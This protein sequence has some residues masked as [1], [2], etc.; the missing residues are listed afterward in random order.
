[1]ATLPVGRGG[2]AALPQPC[3][4]ALLVWDH[5]PLPEQSHGRGLLPSEDKGLFLLNKEKRQLGIRSDQQVL[6]S[7]C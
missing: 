1:M 3:I 7:Y 4:T 5:A 2:G 6:Y